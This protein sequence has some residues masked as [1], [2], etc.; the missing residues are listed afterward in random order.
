MDSQEVRE[1]DEP[2]TEATS[3]LKNRG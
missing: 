2:I 3:T 1:P